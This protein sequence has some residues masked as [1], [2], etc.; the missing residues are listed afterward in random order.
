MSR[1]TATQ[2]RYGQHPAGRRPPLRLEP[3]QGLRVQG[4]IWEPAAQPRGEG[5]ICSFPTRSAVKS[6]L[7]SGIRRRRALL[8]S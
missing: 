4:P 6:D 3:P 2:V 8:A 1:P 5:A 7:A